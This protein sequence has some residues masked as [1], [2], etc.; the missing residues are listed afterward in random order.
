[1]LDAVFDTLVVTGFEVQAVKLGGRAP[2]PAIQRLV[3]ANE[4]GGGDRLIA[5]HRE[6]HHDGLRQCRGNAHEE[7]G[8]QIMFMTA[9]LE[10]VLRERKHDAP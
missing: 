8:R 3:A 10:R 2:I 7:L 6:L 9:R 5:I 4:N 1:V